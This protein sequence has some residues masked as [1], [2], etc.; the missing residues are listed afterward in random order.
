MR[1]THWHA[2]GVDRQETR[3]EI[4]G[5]EEVLFAEY[6]ASKYGER[7]AGLTD[8]QLLREYADWI[9]RYPS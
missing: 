9:E 1:V 8:T 2:P 4:A 7:R 3:V 5:P 6:L